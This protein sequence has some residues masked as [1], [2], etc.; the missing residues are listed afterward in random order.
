MVS[1]TGAAHN[2][3]VTAESL[4]ED[5][6]RLELQK[7]A[8]ERELAAVVAHLGSVQRA[9]SALEV[10]MRAPSAPEAAEAPAGPGEPAAPAPVEKA[11]ARTTAP[12]QAPAS[13]AARASGNRRPR[14]QDTGK[15]HPSG[16]GAEP[17]QRGYGKLTEQILDYFAGVGDVDVR[18]RD[19]AAA[20]GRDG[21]SGSINAV[22]STL[23]RLVGASR[24]RRSGRGLY[25]AGRS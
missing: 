9:L 12:A 5:L 1:A 17:E 16:T 21:D 3:E 25:R 19:V 14:R 7:Q 8:L 11:A 24:I 13:D 23:D 15:P 18:A 4:Q 2:I 20:L 10:L 6:A 22:R